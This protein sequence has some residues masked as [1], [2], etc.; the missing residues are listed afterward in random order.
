MRSAI[1]WQLARDL[2][3]RFA[4]LSDIGFQQKGRASMPGLSC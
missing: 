4:N 2:M 1:A 3:E